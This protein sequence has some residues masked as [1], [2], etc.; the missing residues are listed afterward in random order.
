MGGGVV[1]GG[2]LVVGGGWQAVGGW[3]AAG[4]V[5]QAGP[6]A[7]KAALGQP[8]ALVGV[9]RARGWRAGRRRPGCAARG[10]RAHL[11]IRLHTSRDCMET[12]TVQSRAKQGVL[13]EETPQHFG[14]RETDVP[15]H[16]TPFWSLEPPYEK[17]CILVQC[18]GAHRCTDAWLNQSRSLFWLRR[19]SAAQPSATAR[20]AP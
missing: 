6:C 13:R 2:W 17:A 18:I 12:P 10:A 16:Q 4:D 9:W 15:R 8:G 19:L 14:S 5:W 11:C 1:G 7:R 20:F 3:L